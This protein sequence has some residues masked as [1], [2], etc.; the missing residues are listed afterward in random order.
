MKDFDLTKAKILLVRSV[1]SYVHELARVAF[2]ALEEDF[3]F[4]Q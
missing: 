4:L 3:L 1:I 2:F